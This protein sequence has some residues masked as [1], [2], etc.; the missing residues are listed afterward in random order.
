MRVQTHVKHAWL[1]PWRQGAIIAILVFVIFWLSSLIL[2]MIGKAQF[3]W[4][5]ARQTEVRATV[6]SVRERALTENITTLNT[7]RGKEAAIR[8]SFGVA[9]S[10]E[11]VII[12]V[13]SHT[14]TTTKKTITWWHRVFGWL[15]F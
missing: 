13:P 7:Q 4:G 10:G 12:V 8:T 3:A 1:H 2:G 11:R 9:R 15:G 5:T 6:L 14:A